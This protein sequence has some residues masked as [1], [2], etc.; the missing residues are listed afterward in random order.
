MNTIAAHL[1]KA[2]QVLYAQELDYDALSLLREAVRIEPDSREIHVQLA[3]VLFRTGH[4]REAAQEM[5]WLWAPQFGDQRGLLG[6]DIDLSGQT[7]LLS[8]DAGLGD[9]IMFA[10]FALL[11]RDRGCRVVLQVQEPLVRLFHLSRLADAVISTSDKLPD[12]DL[13]IPFH[14]LMAAINIDDSPALI[15]SAGYLT[16]LQEDIDRFE[17]L[18]GTNKGSRKVGICWQGNSN[19]PNDNLRSVSQDFLI[20]LANP[21]DYLVSLVPSGSFEPSTKQTV[22]S[23]NFND[24]AETAG[25]IRCLDY[26][27]TVDTMICHLSGALG[28]PTLLLNRFNGCWRWGQ[29]QSK[30]IWYDTIEIKRQIKSLIWI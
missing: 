6:P 2:S 27:I 14:S 21:D 9:S 13:R 16:P 23:F 12:H 22:Q 18:L 5:S 11:L 30:S 3:Y 8:S 19:F 7:I 4:L 29:S 1:L 15:G 20:N 28:V 17:F 26:V 24:I 10:R 25:L